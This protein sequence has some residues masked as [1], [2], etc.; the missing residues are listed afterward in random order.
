MDYEV[1]RCTRRCAR[2]DRE[3]RPG[4]DFYSTLAAEGAELVR[5][6]YTAEAWEGPPPDAIGWW[7]S[8]MPTPHAKQAQLAPND[9]ILDLFEQLA[10][11][12]E[13]QDMRYVLTLL[14]V[15]RR[16]MRLEEH[17]RDAAG[18]ESVVVYCPRR[19]A[20]YTVSV[21]MPDQARAEQIQQELARLL[22]AEAS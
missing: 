3:L 13:K 11:Q 12:P 22:F 4:E 10:E 20:T 5:H 1:Q 18:R 16:V 17:Q 15:R 2:T 9:V 14:L 8:R 7:K 21:A 6:D 19:E